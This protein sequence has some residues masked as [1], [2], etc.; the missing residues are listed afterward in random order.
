MARIVFR[1]AGVPEQEAQEARDLLEHSDLDWYETS[2]GRW[3]ISMPALWVRDDG[4]FEKARALIDDWQQQRSVATEEI[5]GFWQR[6]RQ[7]PMEILIT[8]VAA[9]GVLAISL[10]PFLTMFH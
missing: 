9:A 6:C 7:H 5:R 3:G 8:L 10:L 4:D 1:L 2:A